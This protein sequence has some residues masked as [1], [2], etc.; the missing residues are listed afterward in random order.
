MLCC[1]VELFILSGD[2]YG[3]LLDGCCFDYYFVDVVFVFVCLD[4]G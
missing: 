3:M 4:F 2:L 1:V